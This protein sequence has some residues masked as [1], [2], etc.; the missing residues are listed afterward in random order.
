MELNLQTSKVYDNQQPQKIEEK[1][2]EKKVKEKKDIYNETPIR[3]LGFLDEVGEAFRPILQTSKNPIV[4]G[5]PNYAYIPSTLYMAADVY[6][7]YKKGLDGTGE[8]PSVKMGLRQ[9]AYQGIVSV[10]APIA[11]IRGTSK[12]AQ[13]IASKLPKPPKEVGGIISNAVNGLKNNKYTKNIMTKAGMPG[14]II[15]AIASIFVLSKLSKPVDKIVSTVFE[16]T[17]DPMIGVNKNENK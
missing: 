13:K 2:P 10:A 5:L 9:A 12:V 11:I 14:K 6:D 1:K 15:G 17:I 8:K 3:K 7:K 16:K 4:R